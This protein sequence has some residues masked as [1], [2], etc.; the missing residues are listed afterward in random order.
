V[1]WDYGQP[2]A[3]EQQLEEFGLL[4]ADRDGR[5]DPPKR[6]RGRIINLAL[7]ENY[8]GISA[9]EVRAARRA[10]REWKHLVAGG[11]EEMVERL[12]GPKA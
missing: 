9:S 1:N 7:D 3:V 2:G 11:I 12:Y 4:V 8:D 6:M 5:Y 10:G